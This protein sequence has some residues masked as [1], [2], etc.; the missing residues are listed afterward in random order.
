[1][2]A[3]NDSMADRLDAMLAELEAAGR[4]GFPGVR[5]ALDEMADIL[6]VPRD[7]AFLGVKQALDELKHVI[8]ELEAGQ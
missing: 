6:G 2:S 5:D 3:D 4:C 7:R 1:M 8:D